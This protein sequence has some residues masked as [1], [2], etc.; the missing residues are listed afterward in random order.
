MREPAEPTV[1]FCPVCGAYCPETLYRIDFNHIIGCEYC[2]EKVDAGDYLA[3]ME[4][5]R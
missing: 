4:A 2:V 1:F 3:E 5:Q